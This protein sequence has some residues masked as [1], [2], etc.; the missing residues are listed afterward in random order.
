MLH[1]AWKEEDLS[2]P[3]RS[4]E[5]EKLPKSERS[6]P[7]PRVSLKKARSGAAGP[8]LQCLFSSRQNALHL[9]G[10]LYYCMS[11][12]LTYSDLLE[13][14]V[15]LWSLQAQKLTGVP[16]WSRGWWERPLELPGDEANVRRFCHMDRPMIGVCIS[17]LEILS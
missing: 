10:R 1:R 7:G 3:K 15:M 5:L 12:K 11:H 13:L 9:R 6:R 2:S 4:I 17:H 14:G 16:K 8:A